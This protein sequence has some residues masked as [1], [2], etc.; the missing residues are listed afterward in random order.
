MLNSKNK[1]IGFFG[2]VVFH[3]IIFLM[4]MFTTIGR[5]S[6]DPPQ[7]IEIS[8]APYQKHNEEDS[9]VEPQLESSESK[10]PQ[11]IKE[12]VTESIDNI[13][14]PSAQDTVTL[15]ELALV[16]EPSI[17]SEL[18]NLFS[19]LNTIE[20]TDSFQLNIDSAIYSDAEPMNKPSSDDGYILSDDRLAISKIKPKY[21]CEESGTVVVKIW[22]N[23]EG[24]T[25]RAL[26]G[27]RGTTESS[28]CLLKE[29]ES[30]ALKTTWT[31]Y[32]NA[33]ELQIGHIT[34][35]FYQN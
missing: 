7:G 29:A 6:V 2:T 32:F 24:I 30:A 11:V 17:S 1:K 35:N 33:P 18:E 16:E 21:L 19:K 13:N 31:P 10:D 27:V 9:F 4:C 25:I 3:L 5:D 14:V 23:R 34:Y 26:P 12:V 20:T 15:N 22:V 8:Y 28:P